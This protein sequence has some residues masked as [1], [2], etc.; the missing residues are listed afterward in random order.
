VRTYA[1]CGPSET[2]AKVVDA[3]SHSTLSDEHA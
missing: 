2:F 3:A 1:R